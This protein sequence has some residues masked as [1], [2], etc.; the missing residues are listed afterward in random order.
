MGIKFKVLGY[1]FHTVTIKT[2]FS[3]SIFNLERYHTKIGSVYLFI[4]GE[5]EPFVTI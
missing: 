2:L 4:A 1:L 5:Y 3:V